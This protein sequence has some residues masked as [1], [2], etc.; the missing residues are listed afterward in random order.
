[1]DVKSGC[2]GESSALRGF[3]LLSCKLA[4]GKMLSVGNHVLASSGV[5]HH[6]S[7]R[8]LT[9]VDIP[10]LT[11][12]RTGSNLSRSVCPLVSGKRPI[13]KDG[14]FDRKTC[15]CGPAWLGGRVAHILCKWRSG[16]ASLLL[17]FSVVEFQE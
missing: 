16:E 2:D 8:Y 13:V 17:Q 15:G 14:L 12:A 6:Q 10:R 3:R 4:K 5:T 9:R 7:H 11:N 1:M